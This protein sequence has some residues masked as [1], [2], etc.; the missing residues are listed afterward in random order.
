MLWLHIA[1]RRTAE[2]AAEL[3]YSSHRVS[4]II[5][6][7]LFEERK[8]ALVR[9]LRGKSRGPFLDA[10]ESDAAANVDFLISVRDDETQP[11]RSRLRAA[12]ALLDLFARFVPRDARDSRPSDTRA[13]TVIWT[14]GDP[15][16]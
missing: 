7:P 15:P 4:M 2:I 12:G 14:I 5:H 16:A 9:E 3:D 10:I 11:L 1:G 13:K 6:S 8:D